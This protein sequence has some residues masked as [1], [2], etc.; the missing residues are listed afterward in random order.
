MRAAALCL[1]AGVA[2]AACSQQQEVALE[3]VP[4][5]DLE[6]VEP[7][8]AE[9][10]RA[11]QAEGDHGQLAMVYHAYDFLPAALA[12]YR[13]A[14]RLAPEDHRWP[15]YVALIL[16][17]GGDLE[18]ARDAFS[19][20]ARLMEAQGDSPDVQRAA[21]YCNLGDV[22]L[23][24]GRAE[25]AAALFERAITLRRRCG[26]AHIGRGRCALER[27]EPREAVQALRRAVELLPYAS[28]AHYLLGTAY[29]EIG[30]RALAERH[31][32]LGADATRTPARVL[33]PLA[34][35]IELLA[36]SAY[37]HRRRG[38]LLFQAG[39]FY[40][41]V[42][43]F[44]QALEANPADLDARVGL[45]S[46]LARAGDT[47]RAEAEYRAVLSENAES[48]FA[49]VNLGVLLARQGHDDQAA[50]QYERVLQLDP[51]HKMARFNLANA[52]SR[53]GQFEAARTHYAAV[54]RAD[55]G[56]GAAR[57]G[58][59][60]MLAM[61]GHPLE[62]RRRLEA[63]CAAIPDHVDLRHDLARLLVASPD[64]RARD[65]RRGLALATAILEG[66]RALAY[67]ETVAMGH[68]E[69]GDFAK[70]V[71]Q[72]QQAIE[73]ARAAGRPDIVARLEENLA[74]YEAGRP[75]RTPWR[76]AEFRGH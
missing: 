34:D 37:L 56:N 26:A 44:E 29:R 32:R 54:I 74:L 46:A 70:A 49:R 43:E 75:C 30:S 11:R 7:R 53:L 52:R 66:T 69:V 55:P 20:A 76:L 59:A 22:E 17:E 25:E 38:N 10:I 33:D 4:A 50:E 5:V 67:A 71:Q 62:A 9:Q 73:A 2:L 23:M 19:T 35:E 72:Q 3:P 41:A 27:G 64:D 6:A 57:M 21:L 15:Y 60:R 14:Q 1:V 65:G 13:N 18:G 51:E 47:K 40:S 42:R 8:V 63:A 39:R 31:L 45:G 36:D 28:D 68:A 58:E 12:C 16:R 48:V 61:L 24:A